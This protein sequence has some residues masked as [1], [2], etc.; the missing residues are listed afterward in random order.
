MMHR[1]AGK[2]SKQRPVDSE[3][4]NTNWDIIFKANKMINYE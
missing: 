4:F 1:E 2:G 3:K